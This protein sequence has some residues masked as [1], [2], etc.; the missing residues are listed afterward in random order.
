MVCGWVAEWVAGVG[1]WVVGVG[2]WLD[3]VVMWVV[4]VGM[5]VGGDLRGDG[6]A[7]LYSL[8][9]SQGNCYGKFKMLG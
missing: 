8:L 7:H 4:G 2:M 5:W 3:G 1:K 6:V 9:V